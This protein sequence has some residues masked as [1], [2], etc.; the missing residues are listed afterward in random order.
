MKVRPNHDGDR[1]WAA[2]R[3]RERWGGETVVSRG[4]VHRPA[5]LPG[6]VAVRDDGT[7]AGLATYRIDGDACELVTIDADAP[8]AG[9]G[10]ALLE[11]VAAAARAAG[12]TRL[13]LIT[14]NDNLTALRFYQRRGLRLV[15]L[16]AGAVEEARRTL[17]SSIP[18]HGEHG[19][20]VRDE[21]ELSLEL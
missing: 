5:E 18:E 4:V 12:C 16:H 21:L 19:I 13:W 8:G 20:P 9:V 7:R 17:K 15:A 2:R 1:P 10:E 14:T 11:A 6:F 3:L